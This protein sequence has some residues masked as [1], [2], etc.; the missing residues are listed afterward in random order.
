MGSGDVLIV[1]E[2]HNLINTELIYG[3]YACAI[4]NNNSSDETGITQTFLDA[5]GGFVP[6]G[7][8]LKNALYTKLEF[9]W[10][11]I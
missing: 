5:G 7:T 2:D 10:K 1:Y 9:P 8:S 3:E 4:V 6:F 11:T